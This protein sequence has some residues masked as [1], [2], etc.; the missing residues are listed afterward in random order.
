MD[1]PGDT[2]VQVY[3]GL[4][5]VK[6]TAPHSLAVTGLLL[7]IGFCLFLLSQLITIRVSYDSIF[8]WWEAENPKGKYSAYMSMWRTLA[9]F[10]GSKMLFSLMAA[11]SPTRATLTDAHYRFITSY[12][13][14]FMRFEIDGQQ[15]GILS[16]DALCSSVL[17]TSQSQ[18]QERHH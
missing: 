5:L 17:L 7:V 18:D 14:P 11:F 1:K 16:G 13:F 3:E 15:S 6:S 12:L 10:H 2:A 8:K 9:Y 4:P